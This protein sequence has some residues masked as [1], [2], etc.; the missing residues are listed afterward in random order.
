MAVL[1]AIRSTESTGHKMKFN[2]LS[3]FQCHDYYYIAAIYIVHVA[4]P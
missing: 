1:R 2:D 4:H 3:V